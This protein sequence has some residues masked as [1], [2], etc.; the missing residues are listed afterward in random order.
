MT[1]TETRSST[2]APR[3]RPCTRRVVAL[4]AVTV[5]LCGTL[6]AGA[7]RAQT[8]ATRT[9]ALLPL[10]TLGVPADARASLEGVLRDELARL[11]DTSLQDVQTTSTKMISAVQAEPS[12]DPGAT[13]CLVR[14][15]VACGVTKVVSGTV[16]AGDGAYQLVLKVI[17]VPAASEERRVD[18]TLP[19]QREKLV[20]AMRRAIVELLAPSLLVGK[21]D[22]RV[23][24][25]GVAI[26]VDGVQRGESPLLSPLSGLTPGQHAIEL[27]AAG[28][29]GLELFVDIRFAE[30]A[31]VEVESKDGALILA[32]GVL[33]PGTRIATHADWGLIGVGGGVTAIGAAALVGGVIAGT[34]T[35]GMQRTAQKRIERDRIDE[36]IASSNAMTTTT[37]ALYVG[38]GVA[39]A[40]G[41]TMLGIATAASALAE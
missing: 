23:S 4:S 39:S 36:T 14:I 18:E 34:L 26:L 19:G 13:A 8:T 9:V 6:C 41:L 30:E 37:W 1:T 16:S 17:D 29:R 12:C 38:G 21:L 11:R 27:R 10:E 3:I 32:G 35:T 24:R 7:A 20:P 33:P 22:V 25:P 5:V 2:G 31:R 15:G 40:A 28:L